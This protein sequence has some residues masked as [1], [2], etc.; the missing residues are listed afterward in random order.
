[1]SDFSHL[2]TDGAARMVDVGTKPV[3]ERFAR[4]TA[5]VRMQAETIRRLRAGPMAK[6]DVFQV[7]RIAAVMAAK[8]TAE[9]VPLCHPIPLDC[10]EVSFDYVGESTVAI[11]VA[12][13]ATW[14]TGVEME[15]MVAASTAALT[16]YDMCKAVDRAITIEQIR[17]E[18]K[19]GGTSGHFQRQP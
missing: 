6:G 3:T 1:M 19:R 17:L 13:R 12:V 7:A 4:A 5:L 18:E 11:E 8:R 15:A 2:S 9:L 16:I 14:R 10:V